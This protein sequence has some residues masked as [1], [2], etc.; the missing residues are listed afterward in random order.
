MLSLPPD[1]NDMFDHLQISNARE[2]YVVGLGDT[3]L[4]G[5][6]PLLSRRSQQTDGPV[7]RI[8]LFRLERIGD[9]LMTLRAIAEVRRLA[10]GA[11]IDLVVGSWNADL[12][13]TIREV[14]Q[15][16]TLDVP[17]LA[18]ENSG[19]SWPTLLRTAWSWRRRQYDLAINFEG[20]IR[21]NLLL[22]VA[23]S[24]RRV[25]FAMRGGGPALTHP[26]EFS[27]T[28]HTATNSCQLVWQA[29]GAETAPLDD[30]PGR[31]DAGRLQIPED[32]RARAAAL[33]E[34]A[35]A[36]ATLIGIQASAGREI[37]QWDPGR[38]AEVGSVLAREYGA[39]L[40]ITGTAD[41][42]HVTERV[43]KGVD[44]GVRTLDMTAD[45]DLLTMAGIIERMA[46]FVTCDTGP[47]HLA[48]AVGTATVAIF[49]PSL[50]SRYAPLLKESRVVRID[51]PCSPCNQLR[52]PPAHCVGHIPDCLTGIDVGS[53]LA[54]ARELMGRPAGSVPQS[55]TQASTQDP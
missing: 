4:R 7:K 43:R 12:A 48:S 19:A 50:P 31:R 32:A 18:R 6:A 42:R 55:T 37:K 22:G 11:H 40:V 39:T 27:E 24:T 2:R 46:L 26:V 44:N 38:F 3:L 35:G 28:A 1:D 20:D 9:L 30:E 34:Q 52:R 17:W 5:L 51:L 53:V 16:E 15:V 36:T 25:G 14:D 8:L 47:M 10:P 45:V 13:Q 33:L 21:S 49:G 29:F 23:G 41:E 54:A